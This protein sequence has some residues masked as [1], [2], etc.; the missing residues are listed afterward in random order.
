M[1]YPVLVPTPAMGAAQFQVMALFA[2]L[3][4]TGALCCEGADSVELQF[5]VVEYMVPK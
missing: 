3:T 5:D 4:T 2:P 1:Q